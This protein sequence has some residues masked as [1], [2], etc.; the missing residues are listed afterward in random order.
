MREG[1]PLGSADDI[2]RVLPFALEQHIGLADR[3]GF[4]VDL[5]AIE[6]GVHRLPTLLGDDSKRLFRHCKHAASTASAVV[7]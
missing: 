6:E 7:E 5:L 2:V 1:G 3:V 4:W